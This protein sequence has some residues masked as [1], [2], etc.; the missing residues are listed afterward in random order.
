[1][2]AIPS[3][4]GE[5]RAAR[6]R[7]KGEITRERIL[8]AAEEI[9]A[10]RGFD[11]TTLRD[12]AARVGLRNPS[13]Y[14]HFDSKDDLYAAVLE[15]GVGPVL[16]VLSEFVALGNADSVAVVRRMMEILSDHP[17]LCRLV[18]H[19]TLAGGQ[20]LTPLLRDWIVPVLARGQQMAEQSAGD[21]WPKEEIP[22]LVLAM[23][24]VVVGYFTMAPLYLD[25]GGE[26]L[27]AP[28]LIERQTRFLTELVERLFPER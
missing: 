26:D 8:D 19:E 17:T 20:R 1:M 10:E 5:A 21:T 27:L 15:R 28:D 16:K 11:G 2:A 13:L 7:R 6:P 22:L 18:Q 12:V 9:F 4:P 14:N 3:S 24:H 23:Y 25:L